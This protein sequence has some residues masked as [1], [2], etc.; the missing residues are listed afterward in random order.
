MNQDDRTRGFS[1]DFLKDHLLFI[2]PLTFP[3]ILS[4]AHILMLMGDHDNLCS[5]ED[6]GNLFDSIDVKGKKIFFFN[7]GHFL[8]KDYIDKV[9][10]WFVQYLKAR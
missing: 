10:P 7:R 3:P 4:D 6:A 8:P 5:K 9:V 1:Q 2:D